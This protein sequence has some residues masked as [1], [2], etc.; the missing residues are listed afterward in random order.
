MSK[1]I[2]FWVTRGYRFDPPDDINISTDEYVQSIVNN[3]C[4]EDGTCLMSLEDI[5]A[6]SECVHFDAS[7]VEIN[8]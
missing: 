4:L 6:K 1:Q 2:V 5:E 8:H 7:I 3:G